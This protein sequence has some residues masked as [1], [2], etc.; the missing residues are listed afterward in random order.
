ML[1]EHAVLEDR[2]LGPVRD[3][4]HEH[5]P[6]D[7]LAAGEEL[8]LGDDSAAPAGLAAL[9][10]ALFLNFQARGAADADN[11]GALGPALPGPGDHAG[12]VLGLPAEDPRRRR[13]R[14]REEA[15]DSSE[16][17]SAGAAESVEPLGSSS[18]P[19]SDWPC[20][21]SPVRVR[22]PR[23]PPAPTAGA[24]RLAVLTLV[25]VLDVGLVARLGRCVGVFRGRGGGGL[26]G[27]A[28]GDEGRDRRLE[29][30]AKAGDHCLG[31]GGLLDLFGR[32]GLLDPRGRFG[33]Q[34]IEVGDAC[35]GA[36]A[37]AARRRV[38]VVV[39]AAAAPGR[40]GGRCGVVSRLT[41]GGQLGGRLTAGGERLRRYAV[42]GLRALVLGLDSWGG[43]A[44]PRA[45]G[46]SPGGG[47]AL[48]GALRR[49]VPA[50]VVSREAG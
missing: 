21:V 4:T 5:D 44:A 48:G 27:R 10:A 1:D 9:A 24:A 6:V 30:Q 25:G 31:G 46:R 18:S 33:E 12:R 32:F 42:L 14:R 37:L 2:D 15:D 23:L 47:R 36:A 17:S 34:G 28:G 13:R 45:A 19:D 11:L 43:G 8:G 50:T 20:R 38:V 22:R 41:A 49:N 3:L 29:D 35:S 16:S 7:A 26:A 40:C 39:P